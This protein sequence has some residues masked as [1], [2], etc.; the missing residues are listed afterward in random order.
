MS[1][2]VILRG[3]SG[4]GKST[5][6]K[7]L[8][9]QAMTVGGKVVICS[10]DDYFIRLG[11]YKFDP[12]LLPEAHAWCRGKA[13]GALEAEVDLVIIDNTNLCKWEFE[14][15]EK[16][17]ADYS[18]ECQVIVVGEF[19][20][21]AIELYASRNKHGVPVEKVKQMAAKFQK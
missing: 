21:E 9:S 10:A 4:S 13:I 1:K 7:D 8:A 11:S 17:A 14:P 3:V 12:R 5:V 18:A 16:M 15:Y 20:K 19:T 2:M 6:A